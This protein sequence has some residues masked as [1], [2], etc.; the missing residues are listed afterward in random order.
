MPYEFSSIVKN[1]IESIYTFEIDHPQKKHLSFVIDSGNEKI[2]FYPR[3]DFI[4]NKVEL[5]GFKRIPTNEISDLGYFK[6]GIGNYLAKR[7]ANIKVNSLKIIKGKPSKFNTSRGKVNLI[8]NYENFRDLKKNLTRLS[9]ANKLEKKLAID[10]FLNAEFP[11]QF[12]SKALSSKQ[13]AE[14]AIGSLNTSIVEHLT[15]EQVDK[16]L[17]FFEYLLANR[18]SS[19]THKLKLFGSAKVKVDEVALRETIQTFE[20]LIKSDASESDWGDF[21][22]KHLFLIDSKYISVLPQLN[23]MLGGARNVDFGLIDSQ[24]FL[25]LFE[26][27][28]SSTLLLAKSPDRGNYYWSTE[29]IKAITQIEKYL[30]N[31][32]RKAAQLAEDL[33]R[34]KSISVSLVRPRAVLIIGNLSQ[35]DSKQKQDD[36][37]II[38]KSLKN[39]E[40]ITYDSLLQRLKNQVSKVY[41]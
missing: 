40:V 33:L 13:Q 3:D 20:S 14:Q 37:A 11:E 19:A 4:V 17:N 24:G 8:L 27:K 16:F 25:D 12:E 18:Y 5:V 34:E 32:E 1:G 36:F 23:L 2:E 6:A 35:L 31:A 38:S 15:V 29:A 9:T 7:F 21:L 26:I 41:I 22:R 10:N 39:I 30:F 28:K